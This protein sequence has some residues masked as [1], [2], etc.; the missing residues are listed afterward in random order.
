MGC[1][2]SASGS[3]HDLPTVG[4]TLKLLRAI[5]DAIGKR[6]KEKEWTTRDVVRKLIIPW[7]RW[8][9]M[10]LVELLR[11]KHA[12]KAHKKLKVTAGDVVGGG[13]GDTTAGKPVADYYLIHA[14]NANFHELCDAV[15]KWLATHT[16]KKNY[17]LDKRTT[18]FWVD[19][20]CYNQWYHRSSSAQHAVP[21]A[22]FKNLIV[23]S[24]PNAVVVMS[25]W[26]E[27]LC[28][29][30]AWC[31]WELFCALKAQEGSRK[32]ER[33]Q[34]SVAMS[35]KEMTHMKLACRSH[36]DELLDWNATIRVAIAK[37]SRKRDKAAIEAAM[38]AAQLESVHEREA[39]AARQE[40]QRRAL[41]GEIDEE[42]P[43]EPAAAAGGKH[44]KR[45][46]RA[47]PSAPPTKPEEPQKRP[48]EH[49]EAAR[50]EKE[51]R[52]AERVQAAWGGL[53]AGGAAADP[54]DV[55]M[56]REGLDGANE[57]LS[58]FLA[59]TVA[60]DYEEYS[61]QTLGRYEI[62]WTKKVVA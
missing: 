19:F 37:A 33:H 4:V 50:A 57:R 56:Y 23:S 25:P 60:R 42:K 53:S 28:C 8:S 29:T 55:L 6:D 31:L 16:D 14:W 11:K 36:P 45:P 24:I 34:V 43:G 46:I 20:A 10:S 44:E 62:C 48:P 26:D 7:T 15:E 21:V 35:D 1:T 22:A 17:Y 30:R 32:Y 54:H 41:L 39:E 18:T 47:K 2:C 49:A 58:A 3:A 27:P 40:K 5:Q 51:R 9:H 12:V 59:A 38:V 13:D 61:H 52:R